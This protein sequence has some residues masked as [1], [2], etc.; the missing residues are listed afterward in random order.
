MM[1]E[2][3]TVLNGEKIKGYPSVEDIKERAK[4]YEIKL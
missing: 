3:K 2:I 1:E 4:L